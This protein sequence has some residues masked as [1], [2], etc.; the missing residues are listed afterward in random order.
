M[1]SAVG[2][3]TLLTQ[4]G[5][6]L[7]Q[8][9]AGWAD[10]ITRETIPSSNDTYKIIKYEPLGVCAGRRFQALV[11]DGAV[12]RSARDKAA[13]ACQHARGHRGQVGEELEAVFRIAGIGAK[14]DYQGRGGVVLPCAHALSISE[15]RGG[16]DSQSENRTKACPTCLQRR[17]A[18]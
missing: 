16:D 14:R 8:Y 15:I 1:G 18:G 10:K 4:M 17:F 9:Y 12:K 5:A 6:G 13:G 3:Q 2:T 11:R 7:F